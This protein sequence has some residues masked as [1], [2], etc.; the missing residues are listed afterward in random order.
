MEATKAPPTFLRPV[1]RR[2]AFE[3]ILF[4]LEEAI[5][6]GHLSAGDRLPPERE[7]ATRF[8]VSRTSVREAMRVL[9]ALGIVSVRRGAENGATLLE[10]PGNALV[11]ILRFHLALEHVS[12]ASL[13]EFRVAIESWA[14]G[15]AAERRPPDEL[16]RAEQLLEHMESENLD[17][18]SFLERDLAFH[19][20]LSRAC[21]NELAGLV[22]EGCRKAIGRTMLQATLE[23]GDWP[24]IREQLR[25]Q[26]REIYEAI[27]DGDRDEASARVADHIRHFY[28]LYTQV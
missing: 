17:E 26:H 8:Q 11:Q 20:E 6:A 16:G 15:V 18:P 23:A 3:E 5:A 27:R 10:E 14:A 25:E 13:V 28:G 24:A 21:G 19:V 22:L 9:E 2:R 12:M 7:L 4:Q 1:T